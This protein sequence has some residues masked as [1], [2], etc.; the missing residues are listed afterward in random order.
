MRN[1][2]HFYSVTRSLEYELRTEDSMREI[3]VLGVLANHP[4]LFS[5]VFH[6]RASDTNPKPNLS[7][8]PQS[9]HT[10][11]TLELSTAYS[12]GSDLKLSDH[13]MTFVDIT[14]GYNSAFNYLIDIKAFL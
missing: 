11:Q 10:A 5:D 3:S 14:L 13:A 6:T 1:L 7:I 8:F 9:A 2:D 12:S 4:L